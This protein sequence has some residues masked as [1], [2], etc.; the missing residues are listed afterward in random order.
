MK[1]LKFLGL[2]TIATLGLA[3]CGNNK[4]S[5]I[6]ECVN[7]ANSKFPDAEFDVSSEK[8]EFYSK[9]DEAKNKSGAA[10]GFALMPKKIEYYTIVKGKNPVR[11][12]FLGI[13]K[14]SM[15]ECAFDKDGKLV[16]K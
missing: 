3:S 4:D 2:A 9:A 10:L 1:R 14:T 13:M 7:Q 6:K 5:M 12:N 11:D 15:Y 8:N 16:E